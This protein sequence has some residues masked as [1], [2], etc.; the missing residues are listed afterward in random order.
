[1]GMTIDEIIK[2]LEWALANNTIEDVESAYKYILAIHMAIDTMRKHQ[3]I[4]EILAKWK[5]DNFIDGFAWDCMKE[6]AD[7]V[8]E[9]EK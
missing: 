2:E 7:I 9:V 4:Q 3:K 6:I 1:M 8:D 5:A